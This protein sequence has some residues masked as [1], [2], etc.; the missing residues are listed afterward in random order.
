MNNWVGLKF[1][2]ELGVPVTIFGIEPM[3]L[4]PVFIF[5]LN[6]VPK[7]KHQFGSFSLSN[8]FVVFVNVS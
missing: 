6:L 2:S 4:I 3:T 8:T 5:G 1:Y 7:Q